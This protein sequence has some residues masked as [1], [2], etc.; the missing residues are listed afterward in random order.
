MEMLHP[1]FLSCS[2][3][4]EIVDLSHNAL[5]KMA[6]EYVELF[7]N[8]FVKLKNL[9]VVNLSNNNI[10]FLPVE[11]FAKNGNLEY[12]DLSEN[13]LDQIHFRL[14]HLHRLKLLDLRK[15]SIRYL[16]EYSLNI[17]NGIQIS[18]LEDKIKPTVALDSNELECSSCKSKGFLKWTVDAKRVEILP[19]R[20]KC[21]YE[22]GKIVSIANSVLNDVQWICDKTKVIFITS[23]TLIVM[24]VFVVTLFIFIAKHRKRIQRRQKRAVV[25]EKLNEGEGQY[26]FAVFLSFSS[27][28]DDFVSEHIL[29][30]LKANLQRVTEI[31]R[32]LVCSGDLNLRPGFPVH[33]ETARCY[34]RVS[35]VIVLVSEHFFQ[36]IYCQNEFDQAFVQRKPVVLM[37]KDYV[38]ETLMSPSMLSLYRRN[39]R[40]LLREEHGQYQISP[41]WED[42]CN[43]ILDTI[44]ITG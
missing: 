15:N 19:K 25:I 39:V 8:L 28:D 24:M 30:Q 18:S 1:S 5:Y 42:I 37:L 21:T 43:A 27:R 44:E 9:L 29:N 26:E 7:A 36:S 22:N 38:D 11:L 40:I 34:D 13:M 3:N 41:S 10:S 32:N 2:P 14:E 4:L 12:I 23:L 35:V 33:D 31:E 6:A 17:L 16:D 20:L